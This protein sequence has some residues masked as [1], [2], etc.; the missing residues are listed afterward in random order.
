MPLFFST[1]KALRY[2][3]RSGR[4]AFRSLNHIPALL[5]LLLLLYLI[6]VYL[7]ACL[8]I[9]KKQPLWSIADATRLFESHHPLLSTTYI[10]L[11][12]QQNLPPENSILATLYDPRLI[13]ALWLHTIRDKLENDRRGFETD[14]SLPFR[15][16]SYLDI[17][18]LVV[19][20]FLAPARVESCSSFRKKY[21]IGL[22]TGDYCS[23]NG[24]HKVP[25]GFP[26]IQITGPTDDSIDERGREFFGANYLIQLDTVPDRA[27]LLGV[28]PENTNNYKALV[29]PLHPVLS[30]YLRM[31]VISL[32]EKYMQS[33]I[34]CTTISL[35]E[36]LNKLQ[37]AWSESDAQIDF[38]TEFDLTRDSTRT[39]YGSLDDQVNLNRSDFSLSYEHA[40]QYFDKRV[41][42]RNP[43][44]DNLDLKLAINAG[45]LTIDNN[46]GK[47]FHEAQLL[48]SSK[49][50]HFDWRFF[51][52]SHYSTY[53]HQAILHR[54]SRAWLRFANLIGLSTWLAH[55]TLLGWYWNGFN[56]PW[57]QDLDVQMTM[58]SLFLLARNY[59]QSVVVDFNDLSE[60]SGVHLYF[61]DVSP[62]V[63]DRENGNGKNVIDARFIDM[64]SGL[65][66]DITGLA[67]TN[68]YWMTHKLSGTRN[69]ALL[70]KVFDKEYSNVVKS[71]LDDPQYIN[72]YLRSLNVIESQAWEDGH[73]YNCKNFHFYNMLE[74]APL[75]KTTFEGEQAYVPANFERLLQREYT[76]G[77]FAT[78]Y[79][80]W[81][82]RPA[83]GLWVPRKTCK[84]DYRG[85]KCRDESVLLEKEAT[86]SIRLTRRNRY[87][88]S[89]LTTI[90]A[91]SW[92][93][94]R[95]LL[96][97]QFRI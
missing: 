30:L 57:D 32:V 85:S 51:K 8:M 66:V 55:G 80:D 60:T 47:Y 87:H 13:P 61:V 39:E 40:Q 44:A 58:K 43:S 97:Q 76:K 18:P 70:H 23:D 29:V 88:G 21:H 71:A 4:A 5:F 25:P 92:M 6:S 28:G 62:H 78:E 86:R 67:I 15:W 35:T 59:N 95:N 37:N 31:D 68:D 33:C 14:L 1:R 64:A 69:S 84:N 94:D 49:G 56:M 38:K 81:I 48:G 90:R 77:T 46:S 72:E 42:K 9:H 34:D 53:E 16:E 19:S 10:P 11:P 65:Y 50:S 17:L 36:E 75:R 73:L 79:G 89:L 26:G 82:F 63:F 12:F 96:L 93:L 2:V 74:L 20:P 7:T 52:K 22:E 45:E 91:D 54:L 83:L 27:V 24:K 3:Y 41:H